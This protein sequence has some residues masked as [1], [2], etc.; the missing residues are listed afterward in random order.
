MLSLAQ[1]FKPVVATP[2]GRVGYREIAPCAV[3]APFVRCFWSERGGDP[4]LVIPDTCMDIIF[5]V[6]G[7]AAD[8]VFCA[9]DESSYFSASVLES[10]RSEIF[11]VRF[12]AW[13]AHLFAKRDFSGSLNG[14]FSAEEFFG[15]LYTELKL[16]IERA[17]C[18]EERVLAAE[19]ILIKRLE[20]VRVNPDLMNAVDFI[21][22]KRGAAD[23]SELCGHTAISARTLE[24][25]FNRYI[26]VSPKT[27]SS[28]VRY[29]MLWQEMI[30]GRFDAL[31]AVEKY[32][33]S[34]QPHLIHDFKKRHLMSPGQAVEYA[35]K[36]RG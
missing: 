7:V 25:L 22:D 34:D 10:E 29:Q 9:L 30:S 3:L 19:S 5:R 21:T 6:S 20:K 36:S 26:G 2:F 23:I 32:G 11:G 14:V 15:E 33:Y 4:V 35:L 16:L 24:R 18:L 12:Y 13:T 31:D 28:L 8:G 17:S 1:K 27:F